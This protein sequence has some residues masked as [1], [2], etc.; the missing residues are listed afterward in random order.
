[1][2]ASSSLSVG[3]TCAWP[4][5]LPVTEMHFRHFSREFTLCPNNTQ[6][7]QNLCCQVPVCL[8]YCWSCFTVHCSLITIDYLRMLVY[9][10]RPVVNQLFFVSADVYL[11]QNQTVTVQ[12]GANFR[13][14]YNRLRDLLSCLM[15]CYQVNFVLICLKRP[16]KSTSFFQCILWDNFWENITFI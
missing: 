12:N 4:R 6:H 7:D 15:L 5:R 8:Q 11:V 10:M 13:E 16:V 14:I 2:Q 9:P 3:R 1:V